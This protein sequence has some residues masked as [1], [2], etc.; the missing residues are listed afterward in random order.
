MKAK[1]NWTK[2]VFGIGG[3][4]L[5]VAS[6]TSLFV[7]ILLSIIDSGKHQGT[8][9][10]YEVTYQLGSELKVDTIKAKRFTYYED[11]GVA[12]FG[13]AGFYKNTKKVKRLEEGKH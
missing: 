3:V 8:E 9:G 7:F 4:I 6:F 2:I 5:I 13:E 1:I 11:T 12:L 10:Y